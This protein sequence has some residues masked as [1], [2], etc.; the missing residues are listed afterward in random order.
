MG[1][2]IAPKHETAQL[3]HSTAL[4]HRDFGSRL[5]PDG[6]TRRVN[7]GYSRSI[8]PV[9]ARRH[10]AGCA[11]AARAANL[12]RNCPRFAAVKLYRRSRDTLNRHCYIG[13]ERDAASAGWR[14]FVEPERFFYQTRSPARCSGINRR[15]C[16]WVYFPRFY[17]QQPERLHFWLGSVEQFFEKFL[18]DVAR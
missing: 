6:K 10:C 7:T 9:A 18:D 12:A 16:H 2:S 4:V 17:H 15:R 1:D 14:G 11:T 8:S 5:L 13:L 3:P